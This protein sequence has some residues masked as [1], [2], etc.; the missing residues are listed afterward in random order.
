MCS[1]C[2]DAPAAHLAAAINAEHVARR[3]QQY[4]CRVFVRV[5]EATDADL[6]QLAQEHGLA[7]KQ[8]GGVSTLARLILRDGVARLKAQRRRRHG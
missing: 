7:T 6:R 1:R 5:D 3:G 8:M 2:A 4:P